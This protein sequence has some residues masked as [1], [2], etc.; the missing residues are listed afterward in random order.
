MRAQS[1]IF[2]CLSIVRR[3][4]RLRRALLALCA[5][6]LALVFLTL[7]A[8]QIEQRIFRRRAERLLAE[9]QDLELRRTPWPEALKKLQHWGTLKTMS[10]L[11]NERE[12]SVEIR[13]LEPVGGFLTSSNLFLHLDDYLRWKLNLSYQMGPLVRVEDALLR[14]YL[15]VGGRPAVVGASVG[16]RDGIVWSKA[17]TIYLETYAHGLPDVWD[18]EY[19]LIADISSV[20]R[21]DSYES[22]NPQLRLHSDYVIGRPGGCEIC[23]SGWV[24]FTP[25]T[26]AADVRRLSTTNLSCLTRLHPCRTQ[27]DIMPSAWGQFLAESARVREMWDHPTC[28]ESVIEMSG[29]DGENVITGEIVKYSEKASGDEWEGLASVKLLEKLKGGGNWKAGDTHDFGISRRA[30]QMIKPDSRFILVFDDPDQFGFD[31]KPYDAGSGCTP[32]PL[33]DTN[34]KLILQGINEDYS[35]GETVGR[36]SWKW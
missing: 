35:E 16:M 12:C 26:D 20:P 25:Y 3:L 6:L 23:V 14:G 24:H 29:R 34:L 31:K 18:G 2:W 7:V 30:D 1:F 32:L 10:K 13:L 22:R 21:F 36:Q 15:R 9:I 27:Q 4:R 33:T 17:F 19:S 28:S 8:S 11:C 5:S